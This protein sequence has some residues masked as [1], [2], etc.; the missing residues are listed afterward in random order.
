MKLDSSFVGSN[1]KGIVLHKCAAGKLII[2]ESNFV[3]TADSRPGT[4]YLLKSDDGSLHFCWQDL[5]FPD[6]EDDIVIHPSTSNTLGAELKNLSQCKD[7][8]AYIFKY[9]QIRLFYWIQEKRTHEQEKVWCSNVND[10]LRSS[11]IQSGSSSKSFSRLISNIKIPQER[12]L[13]DLFKPKEWE[14][15][16]TQSPSLLN[17][18][19]P[20][21]PKELANENRN[22]TTAIQNILYIIK[23]GPFIHTVK[24]LSKIL[25][26]GDIETR[27]SLLSNLGLPFNISSKDIDPV[28]I[29]FES[30]KNAK[31]DKIK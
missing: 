2:N 29:L 14:Q 9:K 24:S 30:L 25:K 15:L 31:Q 10:T 5:S 11:V 21:L 4:L 18:L 12:N 28:Q 8:T 22:E 7:G 6:P 1:H 13:I 3:I 27:K 16:L 19:L 26:H 23:S 20:L 17:Q